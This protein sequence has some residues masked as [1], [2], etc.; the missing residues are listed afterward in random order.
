M[1]ILHLE[2]EI[3][4]SKNQY[5]F[6]I[7]KVLLVGFSGCTDP[8]AQLLTKD[9]PELMKAKCLYICYSPTRGA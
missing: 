4:Y 7:P 1:S 2:M 8:L 5:T 6:V 9:K 3:T